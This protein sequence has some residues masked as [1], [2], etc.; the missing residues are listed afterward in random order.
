MPRSTVRSLPA[1][2]RHGAARRRSR[3]SLRARAASAAARSSGP[4][5]VIVAPTGCGCPSS[6]TATMARCAAVAGRRAP[7]RGSSASTSTA[8]SIDDRPTC[9]ISERITTRS[10]TRTGARKSRSSMLPNKTARRASRKAG[11]VAAE[12]IQYIMRPPNRLPWMLACSGSTRW[13]SSWR[14]SAIEGIRVEG[15]RA[16]ADRLERCCSSTSIR[17][18]GLELVIWSAPASS[19]VL[20][21]SPISG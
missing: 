14:V 4:A 5:G 6:S 13:T 15:Y 11:N 10:P 8:T 17:R 7:V 19:T 2:P 1:P 21:T 18:A 16:G 3:A 9:S 20:S 12:T